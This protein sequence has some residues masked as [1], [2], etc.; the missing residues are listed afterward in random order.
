[1]HGHIHTCSL[2]WAY[3]HCKTAYIV[4][5]RLRTNKQYS[6]RFHLQFKASRRRRISQRGTRNF[7]T[8]QIY[9]FT[10][11]R[12]FVRPLRARSDSENDVWE[13]HEEWAWSRV[14]TR[15][16][17]KSACLVGTERRGTC[18]AK[19]ILAAF[20]TLIIIWINLKQN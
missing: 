8:Q 2:N 1:M 16:I 3:Y 15:I 19:R 20:D 14:E 7:E 12:I 10:E 9:A 17:W 5:S 11:V 6:E 13:C 4:F 18:V